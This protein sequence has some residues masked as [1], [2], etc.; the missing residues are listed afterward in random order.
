MNA[1]PPADD[2]ARLRQLQLIYWVIWGAILAG[3]LVIYLVFG[4]RPLPEEVASRQVLTGLIGFAPLFVSVVIRWLILPKF[5]DA[6]RAL[7][8][9]LAG[10]AL[11][12]MCGLLGIFLGGPY[13][14][15]FALLGA[16]GIAQYLPYLLPR[17][18]AP[19]AP[20]LRS[21]PESRAGD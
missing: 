2:P 1:G 18:F 8:L 21:P 5:T 7:P 17:L 12:E 20:G 13:R 10:L 14:D 9:F 3:L 11:A 19:P 4:R 6:T 15:D 16:L